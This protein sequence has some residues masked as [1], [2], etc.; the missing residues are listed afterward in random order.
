MTESTP[1]MELRLKTASEEMM[2]ASQF[3]YLVVNRKDKLE[4]AVAEIDSIM[5]TEKRRTGRAPIRLL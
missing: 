2:Q 3:N 5:A 4:Q 1:E